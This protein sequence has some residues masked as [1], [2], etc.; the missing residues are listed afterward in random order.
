MAGLILLQSECLAGI[1]FLRR[2]LKLNY[3]RSHL[4]YPIPF[5]WANQPPPPSVPTPLLSPLSGETIE[6]PLKG[7]LGGGIDILTALKGTVIPRP[8]DLGFCFLAVAFTDLLCSG[9]TLATQTDTASPAA[10][11]FL[12]ALTS[13]SWQVPHSGHSHSRTLNGIFS[14]ICPQLL[15]RFELGNHL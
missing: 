10:K 2:S 3:N 7:D 14:T 6:L 15:H 4:P 8:H 5:G 11:M 1:L 12:L 13:L 9:L